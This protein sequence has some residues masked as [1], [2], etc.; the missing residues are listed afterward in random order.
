MIKLN[1]KRKN[2]LLVLFFSVMFILISLTP[3]VPSAEVETRLMVNAIGIDVGEDGMTVT[4]ET[5]NGEENEVVYGKGDMLVDTLQDLNERYG[6]RIELGHCGLIALGSN[7]TREDAICIFMNVLSDGLINTGCSV[8]SASGS[9]REFISKAALLTKST[10]DG[11]SGFISFT[12]SQASMTVPSILEAMQ[13][14]KSKSGVAVIPILGFKEKEEESGQSG[15]QGSTTEQ[16]AS[17]NNQSKT[18]ET[19]IVPPKTAKMLSRETYVL[20]KEMSKGLIWLLPRSKD[21]MA[22]AEME[23]NNQTY[24]LRSVIESKTTDVSAKFED[25]PVITVGVETKLKLAQRYAVLSEVE[26]GLSLNE[27]HDM[28]AEAYENSIR[29][30]VSRLAELSK[31][32]DFLGFKTRLYRADPKRFNS[33][34]GDLSNARIEYDIKATVL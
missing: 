1:R 15:S 24:V 33:W 16:G 20:D 18:K 4:A 30:E 14:L 32:D 17:Q 3:L 12:D 5:I 25:V 28:M 21:G 22:E 6:R 2:S 8:V 7:V 9:A 29:E 34:D 10:G 31:T 19:E 26:K 11:V 23:L 27:L 13:A